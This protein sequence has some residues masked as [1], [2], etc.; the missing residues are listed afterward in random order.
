MEEISFSLADV[1]DGQHFLSLLGNECA[2]IEKRDGVFLFKN[3][4]MGYEFEYTQ[5][6]IENDSHEWS[7]KPKESV[8]EIKKTIYINKS[9]RNELLS[10]RYAEHE[11]TIK[12]NGVLHDIQLRW[13]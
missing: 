10:F 2:F 11:R 3:I 5:L 6:E 4:T 12:S 1:L 13:K 8:I 7:M 9:I